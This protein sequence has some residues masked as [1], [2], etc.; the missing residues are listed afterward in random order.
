MKLSI[1]L[2]QVSVIEEATYA[3]FSGKHV[4]R[5]DLKENKLYPI[6]LMEY[7]EDYLSPE[8]YVYDENGDIVF[9]FIIVQHQL[10]K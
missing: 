9:P 1:T 6:Y 5:M 10:Y 8:E 4:E 2:E 3:T 7:K